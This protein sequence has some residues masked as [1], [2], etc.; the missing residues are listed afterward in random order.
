MDDAVQPAP[1]TSMFRHIAFI[2]G[3]LL[4]LGAWK[5]GLEGLME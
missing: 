3:V 4:V 2:A 5:F 1:D